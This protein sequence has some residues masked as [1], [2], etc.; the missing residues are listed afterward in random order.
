MPPIC[1]IEIT[2]VEICDELL[3]TEGR[4]LERLNTECARRWTSSLAGGRGAGSRLQRGKEAH[5]WEWLLGW[6]EA[7]NRLEA[8]ARSKEEKEDVDAWGGKCGV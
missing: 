2:H 5:L 3:R 6:L 7:A 1:M 8:I 4:S